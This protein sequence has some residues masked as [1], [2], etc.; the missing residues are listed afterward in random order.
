MKPMAIFDMVSVLWSITY[1]LENKCLTPMGSFVMGLS[2]PAMVSASGRR[3]WS[4]LHLAIGTARNLP[5]CFRAESKVTLP[6]FGRV[7][8]TWAST[9]H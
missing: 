6:S 4:V 1:V 3:S 7:G 8:P 9:R 2:A 5:R